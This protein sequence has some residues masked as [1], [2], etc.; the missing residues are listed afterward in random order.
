MTF[1]KHRIPHSRWAVVAA[2][3]CLTTLGAGPV[4]AQQGDS[5]EMS[6]LNDEGFQE[7]R[8]GRFAE[9]ARRFRAAYAAFPDPNLRKN[10]AVAWFKAGNCGEAMPAANTFL[11]APA[12]SDSDRLEARSILANCRVEMARGA[13]ETGSWKLAESLLD[14]AESLQP[15]QYALDQIGIAR[16]E[17]SERKS[18]PS[19]ASTGRRAGPVGWIM[20]ASG[21]AVVGGT[22]VYWLLT[23]PDRDMS[24]NISPMDPAFD[25]ATR[26]ARTS[27]WL[28]PIGII[29]GATLTGIGLYLVLSG[30]GGDAGHGGSNST[31]MAGLWYRW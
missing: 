23:I 22:L 4:A 5:A 18:S 9:A 8:A 15:D 17:L 30:G 26:R 16:V 14:E 1:L 27:R 24:R 25:A 31:A 28:V 7:F 6:R 21:A 20:V 10:E 12:T 19:G 3:V 11:I 2:I 13:F 29:G